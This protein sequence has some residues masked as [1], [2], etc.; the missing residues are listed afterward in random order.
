MVP[1]FQLSVSEQPPHLPSASPALRKGGA[2]SHGVRSGSSPHPEEG[3]TLQVPEP[4]RGAGPESPPS[5]AQSSDTQLH[6][7]WQLS[8]RPGNFRGTQENDDLSQVT[9]GGPF[10]CTWASV[11]SVWGGGFPWSRAEKQNL[12]STLGPAVSGSRCAHP[13]YVAQWPETRAPGSQGELRTTQMA[14]IPRSQNPTAHPRCPAKWPGLDDRTG[15]GKGELS[16]SRI[17]VPTS[18]CRQRPR[19]SQVGGGR[20]EE[21]G[22]KQIRV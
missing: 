5:A 19:H 4:P 16:L 3:V 12:W 11:P 14:E 18:G 13:Y 8:L 20:G 6:R 2:R 9:H 21:P 17:W 15:E 7:P 10:G 22:S 1:A